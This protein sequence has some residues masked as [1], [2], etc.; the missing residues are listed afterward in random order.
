MKTVKCV[1]CQDNI[2]P[3]FEHNQFV[4]REFP[5]YVDHAIFNRSKR[6]LVGG[7]I[8]NATRCD[9]ME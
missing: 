5:Y 4:L 9:M 2:Y 1:A 6:F 8:A 7:M 3:T